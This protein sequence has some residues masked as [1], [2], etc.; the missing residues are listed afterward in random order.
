MLADVGSVE[1]SMLMSEPDTA[2][3]CVALLLPPEPVPP[4]LSLMV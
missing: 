4:L 3:A 2:T 1:R